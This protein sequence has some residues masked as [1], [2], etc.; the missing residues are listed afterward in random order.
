MHPPVHGLPC[1]AAGKG[2]G[3][4]LVWLTLVLEGTLR[5][6]AKHS[7]CAALHRRVH[8]SP[9]LARP[10]HRRSCYGDGSTIGPN[11]NATGVVGCTSDYCFCRPQFAPAA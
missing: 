7:V 8:L 6:P 9:L 5:V 4:T 10:P 2:S 3:R 11:C 1:C